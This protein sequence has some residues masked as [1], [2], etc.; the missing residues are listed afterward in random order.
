M[1]VL[2]RAM[3]RSCPHVWFERAEMKD[4]HLVAKRY[5]LPKNAGNKNKDTKDKVIKRGSHFP[6]DSVSANYLGQVLGFPFKAAGELNVGF[7]G[8]RRSVAKA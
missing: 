8:L 6:G 4:R 1:G 2:Q 3:V 7:G 5:F